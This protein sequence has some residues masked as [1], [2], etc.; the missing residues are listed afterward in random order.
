MYLHPQ[1]STVTYLTDCGAPTTVLPIRF[2]VDG[3]LDLAPDSANSKSGP[4]DPRA[5]AP[6]PSPTCRN[7]ACTLQRAASAC[8]QLPDACLLLRIAGHTRSPTAGGPRAAARR[9]T[10]RFGWVPRALILQ[11]AHHHCAARPR[12]AG[13]HLSFPKCGKHFAFDG[14]YLHAAPAKLNPLN[15]ARQPS[16]GSVRMSLLVN[17]WLHHSPVAIVPLPLA[18]SQKLSNLS[19]QQMR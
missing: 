2:T 7:A 6:P 5:P 8:V 14:R 11:H 10:A 16:P 4:S 12:A 1:L 17:I 3:K 13:A 15:I 18:V 19:P 9:S